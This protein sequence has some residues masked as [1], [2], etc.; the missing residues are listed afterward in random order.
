MNLGRSITDG[1]Q[2]W[3][4]VFRDQST[5]GW[6]VLLMAI[7]C[8]VLC[9]SYYLT[10]VAPAMRALKNARS[11]L[12]SVTFAATSE[13]I[14]VYAE[15]EAQLDEVVTRVAGESATGRRIKLAWR[16]RLAAQKSGAVRGEDTLLKPATILGPNPRWLGIAADTFVGVGLI[17]TFMGLVA[18]LG[19]AA[20]T[21]G[22]GAGNS[23]AALLGLLGAASVKFFTSIAG[24]GG[25][26]IMRVWQAYWLSQIGTLTAEVSDSI[27]MHLYAT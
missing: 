21:I 19:A 8:L 12:D 15:R 22:A 5:A 24:I 23:Q 6:L 9:I 10:S 2:L 4:H 26:V 1:L 11:R 14:D 25:A 17:F 18:A 20:E 16:R 13:K 7:G 27:D 3:L